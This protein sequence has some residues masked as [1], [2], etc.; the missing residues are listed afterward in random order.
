MTGWGE[1]GDPL[2]TVAEMGRADAE[3]IASGTP[4]I[5][6][7]ENAGAAVAAEAQKM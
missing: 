5:V 3:T 2:L 4:G 1:A 7:M 6:L